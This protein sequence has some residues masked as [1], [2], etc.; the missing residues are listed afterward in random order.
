MFKCLRKGIHWNSSC[1]V[2]AIGVFFF[3]YMLLL[4][5][6]LPYFWEDLLFLE[7]AYSQP[8]SAL[9]AQ[10][11]F[12]G[13]HNFSHPGIP[14]TLLLLNTITG[15]IGE[16]ALLFRIIRS[17]FFS[18]IVV[19]FYLLL[20]RFD[21]CRTSA[22]IMTIVAGFSYPLFLTTFFI[23]RPEI[24]GMFWEYCGLILFVHIFFEEDKLSKQ[25]L[26]SYQG[27]CFIFLFIAMKMFSPSYFIIPVLISFILLMDYKKIKTFAILILLL[28]A[29]YFPLNTEIIHGSVG[30]YTLGTE[31][32]TYM[33]SV[34][35]TWSFFSFNNLYYKT[36][37]E[38][39]TPFGLFVVAFGLCAV[40]HLLLLRINKKEENI[41]PWS[42]MKEK[43]FVVFMFLMVLFNVLFI[44]AAPDPATR[45]MI[46]F[47]IPF[48]SLIIFSMF[49]AIEIFHIRSK[50]FIAFLIFCIIMMVFYNVGLSVLFRFTW[51]SGFIGMDKVSSFIEQL[52]D[53]K[54]ILFYY[55]GT[56]AD[57]YAPI[58]IINGTFVN[59]SDTKIVE[60]YWQ[61]PV[62]KTD[63]AMIN[64]Q[65]QGTVYIV[66]RESSFG[67]TSYPSYNFTEPEFTLV[68]TIEGENSFMD[69]FF[70]RIMHLLRI[71]YDF[72][73]F[74][75]YK[76][77]ELE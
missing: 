51:G 62:N 59:R 41:L 52:P 39:L 49:K 2:L 73:T 64:E 25:S 9:L 34:G 13:T 37:F 22:L 36:V 18:G 60:K 42:N 15:I 5:Y 14:L 7:G 67:R 24:F 69:V 17:L 23:P 77:N 32:F 6:N 16:S 66:K 57:E 53:D 71:S 75:V 50:H 4:T 76:W 10:T 74:Y 3:L 45:Y 43:G 29:V 56:P 38:I 20:R 33:F 26:Y 27:G 61:E 28:T 12:L 19:F 72:N 68:T 31:S 46:F 11:F 48:I 1:S 44:F 58:I 35:N 21:V 30:T 40:L 70:L 65:E 47:I 54:K 55:S 63:F 8:T